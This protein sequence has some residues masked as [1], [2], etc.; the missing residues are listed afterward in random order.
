M[1]SLVLCSAVALV[2][3]GCAHPKPEPDLGLIKV[4]MTKAEVSAA[5][6]KP[7]RVSV[8]GG[9]EVF[10][11][12][13][14]DENNRV[15]VGLVRSNYRY[16]FVRF[17]NDKAESFGRK[18]DFDSTKNPTTE[19]KITTVS[20]TPRFNLESELLRLGKMK[21]NG[22]ITDDEYLQLRKNAIE[23]AKQP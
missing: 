19:Q 14:F 12:E 22:L 8:Q 10:E 21:S 18:G 13:A 1:R 7:T 15:G 2:A 3:V 9:I 5:L 17:M 20:E 11:Y 23:K 4:G 6:G 16:L